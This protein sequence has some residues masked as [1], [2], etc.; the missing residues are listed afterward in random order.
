MLIAETDAKVVLLFRSISST[1]AMLYASGVR[2]AQ[3]QYT[4]VF[5]DHGMMSSLEENLQDQWYHDF[6]TTVESRA[7]SACA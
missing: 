5:M 1:S 6:G 2:V 7:R 4:M 3:L